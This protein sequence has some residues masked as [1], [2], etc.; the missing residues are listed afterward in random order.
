VHIRLCEHSVPV[1]DYKSEFL[2]SGLL[3]SNVTT[4]LAYN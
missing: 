1:V 2:S 3:V 4:A